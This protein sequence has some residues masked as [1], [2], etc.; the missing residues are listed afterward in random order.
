M[1]TLCKPPLQQL[2]NSKLTLLILL[3]WVI[4]IFNTA[5][6]GLNYAEPFSILSSNSI[7]ALNRVSFD[8]LS[9]LG[10]FL[11]ALWF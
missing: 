10:A 9:A 3:S 5:A 6:F 2:L 1:V 11:V 7:D 4:L 8:V